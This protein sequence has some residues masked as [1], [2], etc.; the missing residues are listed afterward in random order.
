[1]CANSPTWK[2]L[3][4]LRSQMVFPSTPQSADIMFIGE[5]PSYHDERQ[6]IPFSGPAGEK[7]NGILKAMG[8]SRETAHITTILKF[9][10][11]LP[12]QT[13][14]NRN[15]TADELN[16]FKPQLDQ[17]I[18]AINPKVIITLGENTAQFL[19]GNTELL[20][21]IREHPQTY[22]S[23]PLIPTYHPSYLLHNQETADKRRLWEDMLKAMKTH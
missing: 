11:S 23:K 5:A 7:L 2:L 15:A 19:T 10:P 13:T 6:G 22:L 20:D 18:H 4:T 17:E 1:M 14:N 12:N 3:G 8:L 9:R 16:A 21:T